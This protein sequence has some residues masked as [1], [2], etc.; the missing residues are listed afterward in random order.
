MP[1]LSSPPLGLSAAIAGLMASLTSAFL[2]AQA[3]T[4][5]PITIQT[6]KIQAAKIQTAKIRT[7][8][9]Q[10]PEQL[11][12]LLVST[13]LSTAQASNR[14]MAQASDSLLTSYEAGVELRSRGQFLE[15][16]EQFQAALE[17]ARALDDRRSASIILNDLGRTSDQMGELAQAID[18]YT[19]A[20]EIAAVLGD[21]AA[22]STILN[23]LGTA[24]NSLNQYSQALDYY[25]RSLAIA[26]SIEDRAGVGDTLLN[27]GTVYY[28]TGDFANALDFYQQ[29]LSMV[30]PLGYQQ[31]EGRAL[32]AMGLVYRDQGDYEQAVSYLEQ[33]LPLR[34]AAN[35]VSGEAVTLSNLGTVYLNLEQYEQAFEVLQQAAAIAQSIGER[36]LE[37]TAL[38]SIGAVYHHLGQPQQALDYYQQALAL[39]SAADDQASIGR[40]LNNLG[41]LYK[42]QENYDEALAALEGALAA[43]RETQDLTGAV[44][45]LNNLGTVYDERQNYSTALDYYAQSLELSETLGD[46]LGQAR[47]N[48]NIGTIYNRVGDYAPALQYYN[49]A[50]DMLRELNLREGTALSSFNIALVY[51]DQGNLSGALERVNETLSLVEDIRTDLRSE[52]FRTS[53]FATVQ[54][55]YQFKIDIL[56]QLHQQQPNQ[57]FDIQALETSEHARARTLIELLGEASVDI[58]TGVNPQLLSQETRLL[59]Q[60]RSLEIE[61]QQ[62][63]SQ[64]VSPQQLS[65]L[66]KRDTDLLSQ[67]DQ[68]KAQIR[69]SS[70][71]YAALKYPTPLSVSEIQQQVLDRDTV[72]L[73]YVLGDEHSYLW[74]VSQGGVHSYTLPDRATLTAAAETFRTELLRARGTLFRFEQASQALSDLILAPAAEQLR[75][76]RL[77]VVADGALQYIPFA[78]LA[79]PSAET[80]AP[81]M[82]QHEIVNAP[83]A[84]T[85]AVLRQRPPAAAPKTLAIL[86]DPVFSPRDERLTGSAIGQ[87]FFSRGEDGQALAQLMRGFGLEGLQRIPFTRQEADNILELVPEE[88]SAIAFGF[89]ATQDWVTQSPLDQYKIVH[90]ATHGLV[91]SEHPHLSGLV[92]ALVNPQGEPYPDGF[93]RL[94]EI[95][96]LRLNADLVV[97]SACQTGLGQDIRGEGVIGL[98]R[99]FMYAGAQRV[100]VSLWN[101]DDRATAE[102]MSEFYRGMLQENLTPTAALRQAQLKMWEQT[103]TPY[104]WAAFTLQGEWR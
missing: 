96:N 101:V 44:V 66:N 25:Q 73:Q 95:F 37:G 40:T 1:H 55:F 43:R 14:L 20:L 68:L 18:Y 34:Q 90:F 10:Q 42:D 65:R 30:R 17:Q 15:A 86:A 31:A 93:L 88:E 91:D 32:S 6:A 89:D 54:N 99:G 52:D 62:L 36:S 67:L 11:R 50:L 45:T 3:A 23:N 33:S 87:D 16:I 5:Q 38:D 104:L 71:G 80:Y 100:A 2:P 7:A 8:K 94:P 70:P 75:D 9:I 49:Q 59:D 48:N 53:Y 28:Y 29:G 83:S 21:P 84:S 60:L 24:H 97:L 79:A 98:T 39:V 76:K 81:L 47:A 78:A 74:V 12:A 61:R 82:R 64:A 72:L 56:M 13:P 58:R 103:P 69:Q 26:R 19:Q 102:L 85:I 92:T 22:E 63:L 41:T 57:N 27:I 35:D 4:I 46:R 51:R 77:L